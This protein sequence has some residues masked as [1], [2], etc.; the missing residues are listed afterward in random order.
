MLKKITLKKVFLALFVLN[1]I[2][3]LFVSNMII[4]YR[5]E[6]FI[7]CL[8]LSFIFLFVYGYL[9]YNDWAYTFRQEKNIKQFFSFFLSIIVLIILVFAYMIF[10]NYSYKFDLTSG[11]MYSF[12]KKT[13]DIIHSMNRPIQI[14]V[15]EKMYEN[16][17]IYR[18]LESYK[19]MNSNFISLKS[20]N[21][22]IVPHLHKL[23]ARNDRRVSITIKDLL[24]LN[25]FQEQDWK[26]LQISKKDRQILESLYAYEENKKAWVLKK[27]IENNLFKLEVIANI[28]ENAGYVFQFVNVNSSDFT[29]SSRYGD[30]KSLP[31]NVEHILTNKIY[32]L[33]NKQQSEKKLICNIKG[34]GEKSFS[35]QYNALGEVLKN[36]FF[37]LKEIYLTNDKDI[38]KC[39][40]ILIAGPT[41]RY[42]VNEI[43]NLKK[44]IAQDESKLMMLLDPEIDYAQIKNKADL[45]LNEV[46]FEYGVEQNPGFLFDMSSIAPI[47]ML[48]RQKS[49]AYFTTKLFHRAIYQDHPIV[50]D[51]MDN[52]IDTIFL[53]VKTFKF[54]RDKS[55]FKMKMEPFLKSSSTSWMDVNSNTD[56]KR[57]TFDHKDIKG[58]HYY[59]LALES[60]S[61]DTKD[62][63]NEKRF[64]LIGD[65]SFVENHLILNENGKDLFLNSLFWLVGQ[66]D[67]ITIQPKKV[68]KKARIRP[69]SPDFKKLINVFLFL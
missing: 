9:S 67:K 46:L 58:E 31:L 8:V 5:Q 68:Q 1:L 49:G 61:K 36:N 69:L 20:V 4:L 21:P 15:W 32:R 39:D 6:I 17:Y 56:Q 54:N 35:S 38:G 7:V 51:L 62:S 23:Y 25:M 52:K 50:K 53:G 41:R 34:H 42:F 57:N 59:G 33:S 14:I 11:G 44:Y 65:S 55:S 26:N 30:K 16:D 10:K 45:G 37:S 60:N 13:E 47:K 3:A 28:L 22:D 29:G 19:L 24:S 18:Y 63:K 2:L 40:I 12:S 48:I 27:D 43:E 64:I 66:K